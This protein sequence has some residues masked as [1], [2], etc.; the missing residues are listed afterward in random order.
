MARRFIIHT[1]QA[2]D[3][4]KIESLG[5]DIGGKFICVSTEFHIVVDFPEDTTEADLKAIG[6]SKYAWIDDQG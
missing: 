5:E 4:G 1:D 3:I 2:E 6:I